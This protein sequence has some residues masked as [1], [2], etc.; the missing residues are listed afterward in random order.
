MSVLT[1][2]H[3]LP[4]THEWAAAFADHTHSVQFYESDD[5]LCG[6]VATFVADGVNL[7]E[8]AVIIATEAHRLGFAAQLRAMGIDPDQAPITMLDARATLDLFM[9]EDMP[10]EE[11]FRAAA[12]SV[13]EELSG[14][15]AQRIRAYGEMVDLLWREGN[16]EGAVRLEELWN[17]LA[18][19]YPFTLLCAYPMSNFDSEAHSAMFER[20]CSTHS[21]VVPSKT[22]DA[23]EVAL[24]Q[25]RAGALAAEIEERKRLEDALREALHL[26]AAA[27]RA[28]DEFLATL[29]HE[30]RTPL[31]AI[32]G[33]SRMLEVGGLDPDVM[34]TAVRTINRSARTQAAL[35]DDLVDV[36]RI[37]TGKF[38]LRTDVVDLAEVAERAVET[39]QLAADARGVTLRVTHGNAIV[40]GD[41]TRLQ[42]I[43]WNL[44]SNSVKFSET[45]GRIA[46]TIERDD[47]HA[48]VT[49]HDDGRGITADFLPHVF[50]PFR[51]AD[52]TSTRNYGGLGLGLAIVKHV[53]ELHGGSVT[54]A[55]DGEGCGATFVVRL[56]LA[57]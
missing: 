32:L 14:G 49:V 50:E 4:G 54:A 20:V 45:G 40:T 18:D 21:L 25:Q 24:L 29:S 5:Y 26:A 7:A 51:Q 23:R 55:S 3:A 44:L 16:P 39:L 6:L 37:V 34:R 47:T 56:P 43:L 42:Q 41:A 33:W 9:D 2:A 57:Q 10:D 48:R 13:L 38:L 35:I 17:E 11:R 1:P 8:P 36:S 31:T 46:I 12:G 19:L 28:K 30:L 53:T 22:F 15:D 27:N 52:G